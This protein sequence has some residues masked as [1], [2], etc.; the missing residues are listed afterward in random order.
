[1]HLT[2]AKAVDIKHM[3]CAFCKVQ[4]KTPMQVTS[5]SLPTSS[6]PQCA[7]VS[8]EVF[9]ILILS[10]R[11]LC[12][13]TSCKVRRDVG[14]CRLHNAASMSE[15]CHLVLERFVS[16]LR[17][18]DC[19]KVCN[20]LQFSLCISPVESSTGNKVYCYDMQVHHKDVKVCAQEVDE[21]SHMR[22][23]YYNCKRGQ[24]DART[25]IAGN[26]HAS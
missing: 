1:M 26:K 10:T 16:C 14:C 4:A 3:P 7:V 5:S 25:R 19:I 17:A 18:S 11:K 12:S 21:C 9:F 15:A 13:Y 8:A 2:L 24:L 22:V 6:Q 20:H 23:A